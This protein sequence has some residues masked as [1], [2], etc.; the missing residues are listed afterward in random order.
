[1]ERPSGDQASPKTSRH[2]GAPSGLVSIRCGVSKPSAPRS[3]ISS[4]VPNAMAMSP[5]EEICTGPIAPTMG[6]GFRGLGVDAVEQRGSCRGI[7]SHDRAVETRGVDVASGGADHRPGLDRLTLQ[8][9]SPPAGLRIPDLGPT[10]RADEQRGPIGAELCRE[11]SRCRLQHVH[12]LER[13][14]VIDGDAR[15][16]PISGLDTPVEANR[17]QRAVGTDARHLRAG[18]TSLDRRRCARRHV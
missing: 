14:G 11:D 3:R 7:P 9:R 6:K 2:S 10:V 17:D 16:P 8:A 12:L 5:R 18:C 4:E 13:R 1:M 15:R